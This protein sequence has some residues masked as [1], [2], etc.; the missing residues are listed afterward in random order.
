MIPT[1][2]SFA[3]SHFIKEKIGSEG[4][5][6]LTF[7]GI[8]NASLSFMKARKVNP[9]YLLKI[10]AIILCGVIVFIPAS[11][12]ARSFSWGEDADEVRDDRARN[13][14]DLDGEFG[15]NLSGAVFDPILQRLYVVT[16]SP[17]KLWSLAY[18]QDGIL[19]EDQQNGV[20]GEWEVPSSDTEAVAIAEFGS[21]VVFLL[22]ENDNEIIEF[23]VADYS[24]PFERARYA[25]DSIPEEE[26][27][28]GAEG[29]TFVP[30]SALAFYNFPF[31]GQ[32]EFEGLF[33]VA[34]QQDG[35]IYIYDLNPETEASTFVMKVFTD[36]D[37]TAALEFDRT[38]LRL[39]VF[40]GDD[41][42]TLE[43]A[44]LNLLDAGAGVKFEVVTHF[45]AP[46]NG[47]GNMEGFA[48]TGFSSC[49]D[50]LRSV[51]ITADGEGAD[52]LLKFNQ[53]FCSP[54]PLHP[55]CSNKHCFGDNSIG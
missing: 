53:S 41:Q 6:S 37:E 31:L 28:L 48:L 18:D 29:L 1:V 4:A 8:G 39:Y 12:L 51:F 30:N 24:E 35:A 13:F 55:S 54:P 27:G 5:R 49:Q 16:N 32:S 20:T 43:V 15:N 14:S 25:L 2:L 42:N 11:L 47:D 21:S 50:S 33:F 23:D 17:N 19:E 44:S 40:H 22:S 9:P 26:N 10:L 3:E 36:G 52:S 34:H 46:L 7:V 45:E 38:N